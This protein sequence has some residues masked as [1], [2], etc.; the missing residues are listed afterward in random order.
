QPPLLGEGQV[1]DGGGCHLGRR[2]VPAPAFDAVADQHVAQRP[3]H[4]VAHRPAQAA[5]G[6]RIAHRSSTTRVASPERTASIPLPTPPAVGGWE[7]SR[8]GGSGPRR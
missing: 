7:T 3:A 1:V 2:A 4:L 8:G 5:A 6:G